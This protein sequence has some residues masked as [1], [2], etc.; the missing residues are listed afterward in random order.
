MLSGNNSA[1]TRK[2]DADND[3]RLSRFNIVAIINWTS[4]YCLSDFSL[5]GVWKLAIALCSGI[6]PASSRPVICIL[7]CHADT[8]HLAFNFVKSSRSRASPTTSSPTHSIT[9]TR[10][11][12]SRAATLPIFTHGVSLIQSELNTALRSGRQYGFWIVQSTP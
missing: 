1:R 3:Y 5:Q 2:V 7:V 11:P 6:D 4:T 12:T 9:T 8:P 10:S